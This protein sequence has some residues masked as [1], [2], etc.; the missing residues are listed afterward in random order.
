MEENSRYNLQMSLF[1]L[2]YNKEKR[3][4]GTFQIKR[5]KWKTGA[6]AKGN[7]TN[8]WLKTTA[9]FF[10]PW[11]NNSWCVYSQAYYCNQLQPWTFFPGL[12]SVIHM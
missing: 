2:N 5:N 7:I 12:I 8:S 4:P 10:I 3:T 1:R 9:S 6:N 11:S